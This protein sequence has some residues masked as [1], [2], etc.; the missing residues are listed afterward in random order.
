LLGITIATAGLSLMFV[1]NVQ[2]A[3]V[4]IAILV[5]SCALFWFLIRAMARLRLPE[6]PGREAGR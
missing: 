3:L 6:R 2:G 1:G 4:C 5:P